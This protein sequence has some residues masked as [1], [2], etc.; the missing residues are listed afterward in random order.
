MSALF[1]I[2]DHPCLEKATKLQR[3]L[4]IETPGMSMAQAGDD[5]ETPWDET[6]LREQAL[7]AW[8]LLR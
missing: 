1:P 3:E 8:R 7:F 4:G 2:A 5:G 6:R